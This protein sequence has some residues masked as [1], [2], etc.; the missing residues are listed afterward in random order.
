[1]AQQVK[2]P[3]AVQET[4]V[5]S[6]GL[7]DPLEK[8]MGTIPVFLPGKSH[9][10]RSLVGYS[11]WGSQEPDMIEHTAHITVCITNPK[12][13]ILPSPSPTNSNHKFVLFSSW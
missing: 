6:L 10:R 4:R 1:M 5:Q 7:E 11:P 12:L 2:G 9:R 8:E 3:N 13:S